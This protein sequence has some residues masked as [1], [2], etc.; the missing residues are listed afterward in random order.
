MDSEVY[1]IM[2]IKTLD[3]C[4]EKNIINFMHVNV[5]ACFLKHK[6]LILFIE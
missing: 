3:V 6:E 4:S 1:H 5:I 2:F